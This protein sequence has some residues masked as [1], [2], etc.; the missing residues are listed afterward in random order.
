MAL[1]TAA[2]SGCNTIAVLAAPIEYEIPVSPVWTRISCPACSPK[3]K[4][5]PHKPHRSRNGQKTPESY[6][7]RPHVFRAGALRYERIQPSMLLTFLMPNRQRRIPPNSFG[8]FTTTIFI[9]HP[10]I[11]FWLASSPASP[12]RPPTGSASASAAGSL[13]GA[14]RHR[15]LRSSSPCGSFVA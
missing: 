14:F 8:L 1:C 6:A 13:T 12:R 2:V 9:G 5:Y 10:P 15:T 4:P 11:F 3:I 7:K